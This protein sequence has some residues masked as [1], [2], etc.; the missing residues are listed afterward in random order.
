MTIKELDLRM[1]KLRKARN[2]MWKKYY[3]GIISYDFYKEYSHIIEHIQ[4]SLLEKFDKEHFGEYE[5]PNTCL[6][7]YGVY[8]ENNTIHIS[9]RTL[10]LCK[11]YCIC[12]IGQDSKFSQDFGKVT[13]Y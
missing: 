6:P 4:C 7:Y 13:I 5:L 9:L 10:S 2:A 1:G 11:D 8:S 12:S 3:V